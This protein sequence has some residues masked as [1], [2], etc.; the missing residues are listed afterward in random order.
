MKKKIW[1]GIILLTFLLPA[2]ERLLFW[3]SAKFTG[4]LEATEHNVGARV[5]GRITDLL[6]DEGSKVKK[7]D[8][9][10]KLD[11]FEQAERDYL[12]AKGTFEKGGLSAQTLEL[13]KLAYED[14]QILSPVD[15]EVLIKVREKGEVVAA[16]SPVAVIGDLSKLW[17]RIF[18]PEGQINR[19][20]IGEDAD[21]ALD[22]LKQTY[23]GHIT[24]I[25]TQAEFTPRNVQTPEERITQTFAV[26]VTLENLESNLRPGVAADVVLKEK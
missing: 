23:R 18:V 20:H 14:Q 15:G 2:C 24:F 3:R 17:V 10:A 26:K 13:A 1:I 4:T 21:V 6:I 11:R 7:G 9:I 19:V 25:A 5:A 16:G 12:R 22:G 8:L